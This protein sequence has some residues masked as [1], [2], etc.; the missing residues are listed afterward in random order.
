[1]KVKD[2]KPRK[3]KLK[4]TPTTTRSKRSIET[5]VPRDPT[6]IE[7]TTSTLPLLLDDV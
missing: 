1:V 3:E 7:H 2:S 4:D 6:I 5:M